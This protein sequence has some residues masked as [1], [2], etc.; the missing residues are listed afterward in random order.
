MTP[1]DLLAPTPAPPPASRTLLRALATA[2]AYALAAKLGLLLSI[3]PGYA[4]P[5]W[6]AAG[7]A[8][9]AVLRFGPR[10]APGV[11]LGSFLGNVSLDFSGGGPASVGQLLVPAF[12]GLGAA[13]QAIAGARLIGPLDTSRDLVEDLRSLARILL[14]GGPVACVVSAC[15][16]VTTLVSAGVVPLGEMAQHMLQWWTGDTVGALVVLPLALAGASIARAAR[17]RWL[18]TVALPVALSIAVCIGSF[19]Y[20]RASDQGRVRAELERAVDTIANAVGSRL[21]Q[22][23]EARRVDGASLDAAHRLGRIAE[24]AVRGI[25]HAGL[26]FRIEDAATSGGTRVLHTHGA[27]EADAAGVEILRPLSTRGRTWTL[28]FFPSRGFLIER[29]STTAWISLVIGL[30][31]T[32]LLEV[33]LLDLSGRAARV[34]K[35]VDERTVELRESNDALRRE[36][37]ERARAEEERSSISR[38]M[39]QAQKLESVGLLA[40]GIAHDFNNLLTSILGNAS[41]ARLEGPLDPSVERSLGRIEAAGN[42]AA[43]LTRQMLAYAG[44]GRIVVKDVDITR[45]VREMAELVGSAISKRARLQLR[46]EP[47]L[48]PLRGDATQI[49]QVVMNLLTNASEALPDGAGE[50]RVRTGV[51]YADRA[52]LAATEIPDACA[53]G[54]Y[55]YLEVADTG[56]GMDEAT[57]RRIFDPFFTTKFTGRG[58]GLAAVLGICRAHR[59]TIRLDTTPGEGTRFRALFP[60]AEPAARTAASDSGEIVF[61]RGWRGSGTV[62][63]VDDEADVRSLARVVLEQAGFTVLAAEDGRSGVAAFRERSGEVVAVILDATM[64]GWSGAETLRE[65]RRVR[66]DARVILSSGYDESDARDGFGDAS[67]AG[68]LPKPYRPD[69]L[70]RRVRVVLSR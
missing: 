41:L 56:A 55:V 15:V 18:A 44:K 11:A 32:G 34:Q 3:P 49:E 68:F 24:E 65:L 5:V 16:G 69:D 27:P 29:Q 9:V 21:D 62:L 14:L 66:P 61:D 1:S 43:E 31:F 53:E 48:P 23:E 64:P 19:A 70:I 22:V 30:L 52:Y 40:G 59:G 51:M 50:I 10:V 54:E 67:L 25:P 37:A 12:I 63:I 33:L 6:P 26:S 42:R 20:L 36:I 17:G 58:L 57:R 13:L 47:R 8:L 4:S 38:R 39:Q 28:R 7:L 35:V 45:A 46:L 60:S 2:A